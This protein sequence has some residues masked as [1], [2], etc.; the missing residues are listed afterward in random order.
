MSLLSTTTQLI[1]VMQRPAVIGA[2]TTL[3]RL[4]VEKAQA[5]VELAA[6]EA[7]FEG[8]EQAAAAAL[9]VGTPP[10][11]LVHVRQRCLDA[12]QHDHLLE[13]ALQSAKDAL[14]TALDDAR[15]DFF[16]EG[17]QDYQEKVRLLD[18]ALGAAYAAQR[19]VVAAWQQIGQ[20]GE[21]AIFQGK[22]ALQEQ[23]GKNLR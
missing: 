19:E 4:E 23:L 9:I 20:P 1:G 13:I 3:H 12:A 7:A 5:A 16:A 17:W 22:L 8:A 2:Q 21:P 18:E 10:P 6:A 15:R 11:S 14:E